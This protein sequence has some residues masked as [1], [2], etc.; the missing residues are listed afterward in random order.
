MT[1]FAIAALLSFAPAP[2]EPLELPPGARICLIGNTLAERMQHDGALETQIHRRHPAH[3]LVIR[4]LAF[5]GDEVG[6]RLRSRGFGSPDDHLR[7]HRADVVLAFFGYGES[8]AGAEG[9]P[10][11]KARLRSFIEHLSRQKFNG[12]SAPRLVLFSPIAHED[13]GDPH[14]PDGRD[15]NA[16]LELYT[17]AMAEVAADRGVRFVDLFRPTLQLYA[18]H[19]RPLTI[20]GIHLNRGG[21]ELLADVIATELF[22]PAAGAIPTHLREAVLD[23]NFHWFH[24]YR[25]TDGYSI[26]GG[27]GGLKFVDGQTNRDVAERELEVLDAMTRNRDHRIWAAAQ[28]RELEVDDGNTPPFLD[29]VTNKPGEGPDGQHLFLGGEEAIDHMTVADGMAV[30]LFASEEQ[31]PELVNPVQVAVDTKGR[32]WVAAWP[33]YPHWKPKTEMNDKLL[34]LPDEDRDGRADRCIV[35]ADGLTNPTGFEFYNG[36][37]FVAQA[38]DLL[39]L[40]DTDGDDRADVRIRVLHGLDSADT[41]HTANSF[42]LDAGG[43]LYFQEGTFH[44][45]Q[46]ETPHGPNVRSANGAV[47]RYEPRT[48]RFE[49]YVSYGF[50]NP[51]GHVFDRWGQDF[52]TDGTGAVPYYG[53]SFSGHVDFPNKHGSAPRVYQQRTRPCGATEI[54]S[55]A[56]FPEDNQGSYL[57]TNVI[58]FRGIL[59]YRLVDDGS[60]FTGVELEPI[61]YSTDPSFRP[62]DLEVGADGALYFADWQNPIIGHMQHNLRDPSRDA[63][64]G[65]IYRVTYPGR[66]LS[67]LLQIADR[68]IPDLLVLLLSPE[69]RV[70]YRAKIELSARP[71]AEVMAELDQWV[72]ALDPEDSDYQ[73]HLMEALWVH[74]HHHTINEAL[75]RRMLRSPEPRAR[76]AATRVL[77]SWRHDLAAPLS[78]LTPQADD[79]NPRVRLEAVRACSFF[80]TAAAAEIALAATRHPTDRYLDYTLAETMRTLEPHWKT[81]VA[82]GE[83][84]PR[85][86]PAGARYLLLRVGDHELVRMARTEAVYRALLERASVAANHRREALDGLAKVRGTQP[87]EELL[88]AIGRQDTAAVGSLND[89]QRLLVGWPRPDLAAARDRLLALATGAETAPARAGAWAAVMVADGSG[90][91]AWQQASES[92]RAA[93]DLLRG[94]RLIG[95][96]EL[97]GSLYPLVRPLL[98]ELPDELADAVDR[99]NEER[100]PGVSFSLY[101]ERHFPNVAIG[102]IDRLQPVA[103]GEVDEFTL[104]VPG[105][106]RDSY[107]IKLSAT[108]LAPATGD[109]TFFVRSDDGSRLYIDGEEVVEKRRSPRHARA[110]GLTPTQSRLA[111]DR[112][113]VLRQRRRR[114]AGRRVGGPGTG[115]ARHPGQRAVRRTRSRH[116]AN[117]RAGARS[118]VRSRR[119]AIR[120]LRETDPLRRQ[121][122][123]RHR[124]HVA[125][126]GQRATNGGVRRPGAR[127]PVDRRRDAVRDAQHA[128]V[129]AGARPRPVSSRRRLPRPRRPSCAVRSRTSS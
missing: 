24:R 114:I 92:A 89:L 115:Q 42:V 51:H 38:P 13:L 68:P 27:R 29:V 83:P 10:E 73:H 50:A 87:L 55:S 60:G 22:G 129:R 53:T 45:T 61:V 46:V 109:Y 102:T 112:G 32:L 26:Y 120:G 128:G 3:R 59:Q 36:G 97:L 64:H 85:D 67:P 78:L 116:S 96:A 74:Q 31:F 72:A 44:H 84:F 41:H 11:F 15:N 20:N 121:P 101:H 91:R 63:D 54:L 14:L 125:H 108:L 49:V 118:P 69:D 62:V 6:L 28:G 98:F 99:E 48:R 18:E 17:D 34:I 25:T 8:F 79:E 58:G 94:V 4:N 57:V 81:A 107:A 9:L 16:R 117:G 65:R 104:E 37:V 111:R 82:S 33:G 30:G 43:A 2:Q 40:Q 12:D 124:V 123:R 23:K 5:S 70:R 105:R 88:D 80:P 76:A 100:R 52:V 90:Q 86:N 95:D 119:R 126:P 66:P 122:R 56:H 93:A 1:A 110:I 19:T 127:L 106:R 21:N 103:T 39:F 113:H 47:Y 75:L 71:T 77:C 35:F 7:R